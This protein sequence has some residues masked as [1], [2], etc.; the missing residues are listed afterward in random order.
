[1]KILSAILLIVS[2]T[3]VA[4]LGFLVMTHTNGHNLNG[5]CFVATSRGVDCPKQV[6]PL[7][8]VSFHLEAFRSF[9]LA[10]FS[11]NLANI[12]LLGLASI[13]FIYFSVFPSFFSK[14]FQFNLGW[15]NFKACFSSP[16]KRELARWLALHEN[17]PASF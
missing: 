17:S 6:N 12:F 16:Q 8:Y 7:D 9:S 11:A 10:A 4:V 2:F 1:M 13:L 14:Q 3:S 5:G 15:Y